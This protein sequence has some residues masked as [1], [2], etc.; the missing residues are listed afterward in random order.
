MGSQPD[1]QVFGPQS[2]DPDISPLPSLA[3][4]LGPFFYSCFWAWKTTDAIAACFCRDR[5]S[6]SLLFATIR[7]MLPWSLP[8]A[9]Q[10]LA[11]YDQSLPPPLS[12]PVPA[13]LPES[14]KVRALLTAAAG[15]CCKS[16]MHHHIHHLLTCLPLFHVNPPRWWV[17]DVMEH[18]ATAKLTCSSLYFAS[19]A[20]QAPPDAQRFLAT[21]RI[22]IAHLFTFPYSPL[23]ARRLTVQ[24]R[25]RACEILRLGL[26]CDLQDHELLSPHFQIG[27]KTITKRATTCYDGF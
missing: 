24:H 15:G 18:A 4:R 19:S 17:V 16:L 11:V 2:R 10:S 22:G 26:S 23:R 25:L 6:C 5:R 12:R 1:I 3:R 27:N 20:H 21:L 7:D 8:G 14:S 13:F 9:Q